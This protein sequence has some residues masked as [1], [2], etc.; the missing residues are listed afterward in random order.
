M[1][2]ARDEVE[3]DG[4]DDGSGWLA[5]MT[6][7]RVEVMAGDLRF[8][9]LLW[10]TAVEADA[11]EADELEPMPGIGPMTAALEAFA[12][13]FG[14]DPDVAQA[15][16]ERSAAAGSDEVPGD[17]AR[18]VIAAM[19]GREKTALLVRLLAGDPHVAAELWAMVRMRLAPET[20][21]SP[22]APRT[23]GELR[24]RARAIRLA[25][26]RA[27]ADKAAE[28]RRRQAEAAEQAHR[29]RLETIRRRGEGVWREVE[30]EIG[31]RNRASYDKAA[32]LLSDLRALA[33]KQ[34]TIEEFLH[35]LHA[36]RVR[37]VRK[38]R[39]IERLATI[40]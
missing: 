10:L 29:I 28:E 27:E 40:G 38:E 1:D 37:H 35:R 11:F 4:W 18:R 33:E 21:I 6:P 34:G 26:E 9:Y 13:F 19:T 36:I 15:A 17:A 7:L 32:I 23:V 8:F 25:R 22:P 24:D 3:L 16:A 30:D 39:F 31:R 2:I 14:I 5:A 12:N 20:R